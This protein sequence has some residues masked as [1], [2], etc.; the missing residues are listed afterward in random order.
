[1]RIFCFLD[2]RRDSDA[3]REIQH[4]LCQLGESFEHGAPAGQNDT[5]ACLPLISRVSNFVAYEMNDFFRA[6]LKDVAQDLLRDRAR[7]A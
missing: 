4:L 2:P 3:D 7:L 5:G 6:R 1:M